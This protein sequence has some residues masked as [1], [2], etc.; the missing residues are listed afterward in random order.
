MQMQKAELSAW[1][2]ENQQGFVV[3]MKVSRH[4]DGGS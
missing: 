3:S 1:S 2:R 4:E